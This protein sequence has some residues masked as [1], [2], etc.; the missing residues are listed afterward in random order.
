MKYFRKFL[1]EDDGA[2]LIQ[3]AIVLAVVAVLAIAIQGITSSAKNK[4]DEAKD[5]ID[6]IEMGGN[7]GNGEP[8]TP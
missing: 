2:E 1:K 6:G 7:P 5:M 3:F 4:V 8:I